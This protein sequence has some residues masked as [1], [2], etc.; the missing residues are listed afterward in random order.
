MKGSPFVHYHCEFDAES[1]VREF[2]LTDQSPTPGMLTNF[3]GVKIPPADFAGFLDGRDGEVE[4]VPIPANWHAD[5]AEWAAALRAVDEAIGTFRIIELGCGWGCWLNNMGAAA[6][7]RGLGLDLIGI[8]GDQG[9]VE[10]ARRILA[11]NG[12]TE[13]DYR[14]VHGIA[15]P[16][17]GKAL[18]PVVE[19]PGATWG[20]APRFDASEAE[21]AEAT[22]SG[23]YALLDA[24]PLD[25][26]ARGQPVDLLHVDI[27][28]GETAFLADNLADLN[29][30]VKRVLIGTHSRPIEGDI[31]RM[32]LE[33][34]W[35]LEMER[36]AILGI[37]G[38]VPYVVVDGVQAYRN[39]RLS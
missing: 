33:A 30:L 7:S 20:S 5:L 31:M 34:G 35:L 8:E 2:A 38:G 25:D 9:H 17:R 18:F 12:F 28:G 19:N 22:A 3:L 14:V 39:S 32:M 15:A 37:A 27:Q 13:A 26:L 16:E 24:L 1:L 21:I 6:R 11:T 29:R 36:P 23:D 4:G 10:S